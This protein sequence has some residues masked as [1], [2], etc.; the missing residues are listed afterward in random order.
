VEI[1]I[2]TGPFIE[3]FCKFSLPDPDDDLTESV[4]ASISVASR[5]ARRT[6][7]RLKISARIVSV[8]IAAQ[9]AERVFGR[10]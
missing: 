5:V 8:R 3:D 1:R 4:I 6:T 9:F 2:S 7:A 10:L